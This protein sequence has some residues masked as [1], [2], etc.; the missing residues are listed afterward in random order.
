MHTLDWCAVLLPA[1]LAQE[2]A[3]AIA[4][5]STSGGLRQQQVMYDQARQKSFDRVFA[6]EKTKL[7]LHDNTKKEGLG[8]VGPG[9]YRSYTTQLQQKVVGEGHNRS[10]GHL[11]RSGQAENLRSSGEYQRR[12]QEEV[13]SEGVCGEKRRTFMMHRSAAGERGCTVFS[14]FFQGVVTIDDFSRIN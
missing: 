8:G 5:K 4:I 14:F 6:L 3:S 10:S 7:P 11:E 9:Q 2:R 1:V 13:L 12:V